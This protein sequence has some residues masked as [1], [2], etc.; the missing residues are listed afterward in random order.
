MPFVRLMAFL[1]VVTGA[2][3]GSPLLT[4][5]AEAQQQLIPPPTPRVTTIPPLSTAEANMLGTQSLAVPRIEM[6]TG[7][8][9]LTATPALI[10]LSLLAASSFTY[11]ASEGA[12]KAF[13][14]GVFGSVVTAALGGC[15]LGHGIRRSMKIHRARQQIAVFPQLQLGQAFQHGS[16]SLRA[17]F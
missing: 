8:I 11:G 7:S 17:T 14:L 15:L 13:G 6:V 1:A 4:S 16:V 5:H 12:Q 2:L 10:G 3:L 9:L